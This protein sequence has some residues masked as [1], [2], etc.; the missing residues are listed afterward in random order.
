[1]N[2]ETMRE[3][4]NPDALQM[5]DCSPYLPIIEKVHTMARPRFLAAMNKLAQCM[6]PNEIYLEV[7]SYQGGSLIGT[8]LNN[9]VQAVAVDSFMCWPTNNG[10]SIIENFTKEF[11][12]FDR[13]KLYAEDFREFFKRPE[14][15]PNIGLYYYDGDHSEEQTYLGLE[16]AWPFISE[17]YGT[18]VLD[19]TFLQ[20]VCNGINHFIG[21][22][23]DRLRVACAVSPYQQYHPDWWNGTIFL[24]KMPPGV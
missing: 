21:N 17:K 11:G 24:H 9:N 19:D 2:L 14:L 5:L 3:A 16:A 10:I 8:L 18:I 7:G 12:V 20:C 22:H 4:L 6:N 13:M 23:Y 15:K 1:M